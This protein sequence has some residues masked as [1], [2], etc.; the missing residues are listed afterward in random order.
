MV[1]T[2]TRGATV[3]HPKAVLGWP[4]T[5]TGRTVV[6]PIL[7]TDVV[8]VTIRPAGPRAGSLT[9]LW[10]DEVSARAAFD[11][12][13]TAGAPWVWAVP[14]VLSETL[15]A[16]VLDATMETAE[17]SGRRWIVRTTVQEVGP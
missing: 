10:W 9:T 12:L 16:H 4:L 15:T 3:L 7:G 17:D 5:R 2:I 8:E 13:A 6:H 1:D 14:G 11:A